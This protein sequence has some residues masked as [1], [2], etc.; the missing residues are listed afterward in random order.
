L[1]RGS[2]HLTGYRNSTPLEPGNYYCDYNAGVIAATAIMAALFWRRRTGRGQF[3]EI[4][5]RDGLTQLIG[6]SLLDYAM[7]GRVQ[8]RAANAD[9]YRAPHNVCRCAGA[10]SWL[11]LSVMSDAEWGCLCRARP[12]RP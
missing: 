12:R 1:G 9:P 11:A 4:A 2:T 6:E 7:N 5:M 10:D 8:E 3:I